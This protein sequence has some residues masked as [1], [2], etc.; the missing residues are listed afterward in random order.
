M[1]QVPEVCD[2]E[3]IGERQACDE[4]S[5]STSLTKTKSDTR[6]TG[7]SQSCE[8]GLKRA[9]PFGVEKKIEDET[10]SSETDSSSVSDVIENLDGHL[11]PKPPLHEQ[12]TSILICCRRL[13]PW[14]KLPVPVDLDVGYK[15]FTCQT[16]VLSQFSNDWVQLRTGLSILCPAGYYVECVS[17]RFD[18]EVYRTIVYR[19]EL[20]VSVRLQ[21]GID[22]RT[23]AEGELIARLLISRA[24]TGEFY[25]LYP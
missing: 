4:I 3:P 7:I 8:V 19:G 21:Q 20:I 17:C 25:A 2:K 9:Y 13:V 12:V 23:L 10:D 18:I 14:A 11:S 1:S 5:Q 24:E 15:V 22:V 16:A 6:Q